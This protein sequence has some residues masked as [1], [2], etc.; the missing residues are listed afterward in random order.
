MLVAGH[1]FA[2]SMKTFQVANNLLGNL[3]DTL[4]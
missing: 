3:I 4:A 2:A 1:G